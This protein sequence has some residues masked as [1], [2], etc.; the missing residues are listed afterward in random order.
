MAITT[1]PGA[2]TAAVRLIGPLTATRAVAR[3]APGDGPSP[4]EE[5]PALQSGTVGDWPLNVCDETQAAAEQPTLRAMAAADLHNV[6]F[7]LGG[8]V[9]II[10]A[11]QAQPQP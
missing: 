2:M 5:L 1:A 7:Q 9:R 4:H 10:P 11:V 8:D 3:P 6:V